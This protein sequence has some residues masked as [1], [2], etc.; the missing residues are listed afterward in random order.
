M[1]S[2][3]NQRGPKGAKGRAAAIPSAGTP[4]VIYLERSMPLLL[5]AICRLSI[6]T[7]SPR[8]LSKSSAWAGM[9]TW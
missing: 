1:K 8:M 7:N 5:R 9:F 4:Q 3:N 2:R 6:P